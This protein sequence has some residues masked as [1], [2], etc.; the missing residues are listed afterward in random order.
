MDDTLERIDNESSNG[1][2]SHPRSVRV[3]ASRRR[4]GSTFSRRGKRAGV[5]KFLFNLELDKTFSLSRARHGS[6]GPVYPLA[7]QDGRK[8]SIKTK[9]EAM[10]AVLH[11]TL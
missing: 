1:M 2:E 9:L 3:D 4:R 7:Y 11:G 8:E 10:E 5:E 6:N